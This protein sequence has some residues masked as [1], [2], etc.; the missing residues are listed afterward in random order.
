MDKE[1][2]ISSIVDVLTKFRDSVLAQVKENNIK[3]VFNECDHLRDGVLPHH[4]IRV[5]DRGNEVVNSNLLIAFVLEIP[6]SRGALRST[7]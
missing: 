1:A 4:G 2:A 6:E 3:G 5:E 7:P